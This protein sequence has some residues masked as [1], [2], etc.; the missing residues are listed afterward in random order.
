MSFWKEEW[1]DKALPPKGTRVSKGT[2][3]RSEFIVKRAQGHWVH[4]S[5]RFRQEGDIMRE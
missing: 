1:E 3:G 5:Q 2:D 4:W